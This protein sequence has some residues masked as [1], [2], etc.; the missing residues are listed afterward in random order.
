MRRAVIFIILIAIAFGVAF[1]TY[2]AYSYHKAE[3]DRND[4]VFEELTLHKNGDV[5]GKF[6]CEKEGR[7]I[8]DYKYFVADGKL[9]I[10]LYVTAGEKR[11]LETDKD[12]YIE[13]EFKNLGKIEKIYYKDSEK[14]HV[15]SFNEE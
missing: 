7:K 10:T 5:S 13:L 6:L 14:D 1:T 2:T 15:L 9:Y 3:L 8:C 4:F 11:A 12:G